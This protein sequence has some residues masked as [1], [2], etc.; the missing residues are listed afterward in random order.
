MH[1]FIINIYVL[2]KFLHPYFIPE[3]LSTVLFPQVYNYK[4]I[5]SC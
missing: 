3:S 1:I 2:S 5:Q 4:Y